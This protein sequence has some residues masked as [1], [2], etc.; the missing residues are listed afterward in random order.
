MSTA[1]PI[2][3]A[4]LSDFATAVYAH[5]G[6]PDADAR[7]LA[8]SLVQADLWGHQ[9]HGVL[10]LGWYLARLRAGSMQ[11]Q[12][13]PEFVMD[14][15]AVAVIDGHHG[16]GQVLAAR[17]ADEAIS[18][19]KQHGIGAVGVRQS[20]H[21]GTAMYYTLRAPRE[22]CIA[23]LTTNASP[24]MAPWGGR[25]K[26]V[27]NNPWSIAAPAGRHAPMVMDIANTGV[28][29]GK[30]YLARQR[31]EPIPEGWAINA[32]GAPTTD[33]QEAIDGIILPMA[34]HKGYIISMMMDVLAGVLTGSG[35]G[36]QVHG[37]YQADK[38][39]CCGHMMI[40]MDVAAFQPPD[41]FAVRMEQLVAAIKA[42]PVAAG[43]DEVFYPGE[44]EA[45]ND[46][47]QR[48]EGIVLPA[49]TLADLAKIAR[50]NG[51]DAKLPF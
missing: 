51:L 2:A 33:A 35:F 32:A 48:R 27:G 49:D 26:L 4:A 50:E 40:A 39:S 37:P 44:I 12:T 20:N 34:Q 11:A 41:E 45:R 21:F 29:R 19:A 38:R 47:R 18:R 16:V 46:A 8:D 31:G 1:T 10:R 6:V 28:A 25:E 22:G 3:A 5:A 7:L 24:A 42:V 36:A 14:G 43:Y 13:T 17:A 15:G 23:F 30:V 9:S